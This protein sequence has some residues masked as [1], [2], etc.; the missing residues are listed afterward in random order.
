VVACDP[1][2]T[3]VGADVWTALRRPFE[4]E[5]EAGL[6]PMAGGWIGLLGYELAGTVER[7]PAPRP[8]PGGPPVAAL[9]R[10]E[11]V[12][13]V[14]DDGRCT[15]AGRDRTR[16]ADLARAAR[17]ADRPAARGSGGPV[18][19]SLSPAAY[20]EAAE[21]VRRL[22]RAGDCYQVNLVQRLRA[23]WPSG[24]LALARGL[25]AAAG[26]A[27]HRAYLG[28]P[29]GAVVSASPERLV[30][31]EGGVAS[32]EPVK[33][34]APPG[35]GAEL[36]RSAKDRAEHVMIVDLVRNDLGRV[37]RYG[38][39]S[40]PRLMAPLAAGYVE[41]LVSEVRAE[42]RPEAAPGDVLRAVFPGG[43]VTGAP[44]VRAMEVIRALEPV[45]RGPA[46]GSVVAV[47]TDGSVEASVAIRTAW[48]VDD[49]ARYWC[50]GA[51]TWDS[52]PEAERREAWAKAAPFL[53]ALGRAA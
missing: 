52:D 41:H 38:G 14:D 39:V 16:L 11:A 5:A 45:A 34:T 29:G 48:L 19:S 32:S 4:A 21:A 53:R 1:I 30:S 26:P 47:G 37:A 13:L 7:L 46:F 28:L 27:S 24:P 36:A 8:D 9:A 6:E 40:V 15:L 12:A 35:R 49:E 23:R 17:R 22:I 2:E 51:V 43:S 3:V 50:G 42:L 18:D 20:R 33:G 31:V 10:Y 25:W 44:K